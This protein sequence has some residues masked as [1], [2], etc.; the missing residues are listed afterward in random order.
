MSYVLAFS[1]K[2]NFLCTI[3]K[4]LLSQLENKHD[5]SIRINEYFDLHFDFFFFENSI[6][7]DM[8]VSTIMVLN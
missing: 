6:K 4:A 3:Y 8:G 7:E 5:S 2:Y 1:C